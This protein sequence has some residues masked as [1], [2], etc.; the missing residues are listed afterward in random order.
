M[1]VYIDQ[2][3]QERYL[4]GVNSETCVL[5]SAICAERTAL[6]QLRLSPHGYRRISTIYITATAPGPISP[7][8]LCREF[9]QE[10][11][12]P[13]T[14][15]FLFSPSF[16]ADSIENIVPS[17]VGTLEYDSQTGTYEIPKDKW[18]CIAG[19]GKLYPYPP[20]YHKVA[21]D[22]LVTFGNNYSVTMKPFNHTFAEQCLNQSIHLNESVTIDRSKLIELL[23]NLYKT[24]RTVAA[25]STPADQLYPIHRAAG[26]I[27]S[28]GSIIHCREQKCL[29]YGCTR[30]AIVG[31]S[32]LV[33]MHTST[34]T[35]YR[36]QRI[37]QPLVL[38]QTDQ[39]GICTAPAA[40]PRA[41]LHE[42]GY[43]TLVIPIHTVQNDLIITTIAALS[44]ASPAITLSAA[45]SSSP[46]I[47]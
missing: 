14:R 6:L 41:W 46:L 29:E 11:T 33:T 1:V 28:D 36:N 37:V 22:N 17:T 10:Y 9:M 15:I 43:D 34:T 26:I 7:G 21:R 44:P 2:K 45:A 20:L 35:N 38:I 40:A 16:T 8:M 30:D 3:G 27:F 12:V 24:V 25:E 32:H 31:L 19:I 47:V 23:V 18:V 4:T 5:P 13:S 39:F 42:Y